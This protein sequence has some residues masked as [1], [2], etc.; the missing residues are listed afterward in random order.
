ML[1]SGRYKTSAE[2]PNLDREYADRL[3]REKARIRENL[4][5]LQKMGGV[6]L[7]LVKRY[8][9]MFIWFR[10]HDTRR[11]SKELM[12]TYRQKIRGRLDDEKKGQ[13]KEVGL[14]DTEFEGI[15]KGTHDED[16]NKEY[17]RSRSVIGYS[18]GYKY[19]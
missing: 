3:Q 6:E 1:N 16:T 18:T 13:E 2:D 11:K 17:Y 12:D 14:N 10:L 4:T 7:D 15:Y 9:V 5:K 19:E 8:A